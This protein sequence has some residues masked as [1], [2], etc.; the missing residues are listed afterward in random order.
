MV[1]LQHDQN[2]Q[3]KITLP[4]PLVLAKKWKK[5]D[6]LYFEL[7]NIGNIIIKKK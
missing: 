4:K 1:R 7:D 5:G 3:F 6:V 2:S